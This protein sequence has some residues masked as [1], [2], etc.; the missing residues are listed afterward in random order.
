[1][2]DFLAKPIDHALLGQTIVKWT[3]GEGAPAG[4]SDAAARAAEGATEAGSAAVAA[5]RAR[6]SRLELERLADDLDEF[7]LD[8]LSED[9]ADETSSSA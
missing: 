4:A 7:F 8:D 3:D 6:D 2:D 1:M 5:G 9:G